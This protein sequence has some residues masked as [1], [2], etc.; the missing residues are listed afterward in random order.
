MLPAADC[1]FV[2]FN[3]AFEIVHRV[4][5]KP[6]HIVNSEFGRLGSRNID[7]LLVG[8]TDPAIVAILTK[9]SL[10]VFATIRFTRIRLRSGPAFLVNT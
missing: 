1:L 5:P 2:A 6:I 4:I 3:F 8:A 9:R 10:N 7:A